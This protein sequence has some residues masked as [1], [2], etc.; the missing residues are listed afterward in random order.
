MEET[1]E[2][3]GHHFDLLRARQDD[4]PIRGSREHEGP[5]DMAVARL[6]GLA[7]AFEE[8]LMH[9]GYLDERPQRA[10][11]VTYEQA[12]FRTVRALSDVYM[13]S[14][15]WSLTGAMEFAVAN[16]PHGELLDDSLHLWNEMQT[17][18]LHVGWHAQMV[19]GKVHFMKLFRDRAQQ[20]GEDF[21]LKDFMDEFYAAGVIP[22]SLIRWELTGYD[23]EIKLLWEPS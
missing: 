1:H 10:R 14:Q 18:L 16:A 13:H 19:A 17:T 8:L 21:N 6:E 15:D 11:S 2:L 23:D 9:A 20:L 22:V 3:V 5:Y 12:A 7:F 4:R